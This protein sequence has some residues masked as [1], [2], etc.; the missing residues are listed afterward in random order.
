MA[1][2]HLFEKMRRYQIEPN[3][4]SYAAVLSC[5]GNMDLFDSKIA[6]R[7]ILDIEKQVRTDW[8]DLSLNLF[9]GSI[10]GYRVV[11]IFSLECLNADHVQRISK[12]L[13]TF[14]PDFN[15]PL[16]SSEVGNKI[17]KDIYQ[18]PIPTSLVSR[19]HG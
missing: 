4:E 2:Q 19:V 5:L 18:S 9:D 1:L 12:V 14:R 3:L 10:Q 6:R 8:V 15:I 16:R 7:I 17:V 11:D 13:K